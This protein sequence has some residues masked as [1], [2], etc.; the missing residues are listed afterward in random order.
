LIASED[1]ND[2]SR[3]HHERR[4]REM[5]DEIRTGLSPNASWQEVIEAFEPARLYYMKFLHSAEE[6]RARMNPEPFRID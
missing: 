3:G 5:E 4:F 2:L 6:R 1:M